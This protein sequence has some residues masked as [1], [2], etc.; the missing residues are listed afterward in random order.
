MGHAQVNHIYLTKRNFISRPYPKTVPQIKLH[1]CIAGCIP[2]CQWNAQVNL[3][4]RAMAS[5]D[6]HN[7]MSDD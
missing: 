4:E 1:M 6:M 2:D 3:I 7:L 5:S